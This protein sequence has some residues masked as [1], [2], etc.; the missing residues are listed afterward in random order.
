M[1]M[2]AALLALRLAVGGLMVRSLFS[3][4]AGFLLSEGD[5][6]LKWRVAGALF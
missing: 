6:P 4:P 3:Q 5:G 1:A 2:A